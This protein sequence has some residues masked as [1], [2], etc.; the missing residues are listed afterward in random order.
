M[1]VGRNTGDLEFAKDGW[2]GLI[3]DVD[4]PQRVDLFEGHDVGAVAIKACTPDAFAWRNAVHT[5]GLNEDLF[6]RVYIHGANQRD[7]LRGHRF[8]VV[9]PPPRPLADGR[10]H[11]K[12]AF[13]LGE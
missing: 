4:D 1:D 6:S 11:P 9:H 8:G 2:V 12:H 10:R 3:S 13:V 5:A 7:E